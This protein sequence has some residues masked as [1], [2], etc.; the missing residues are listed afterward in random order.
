MSSEAVFE[1]YRARIYRHIRSLVRNRADAEDLTQ[2]TFLRA[3]QRLES[4]KEPAALGVWLYRI[5]THVCYDHLRRVS[6]QPAQADDAAGQLEELAVEGPGLDQLVE[7]AE[8]IACGEVFLDRLPD[9]YRT[10]ILLH[11]LLDLSSV[12]IARLLRC[13]PGSVKIRLHRAR[14][15]FRAALEAGC[16]FYRNERGALVGEPKPRAP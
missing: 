9:G 2:E 11:D 13:T 15:R 14:A 16:E 6:R 1:Q 3:H 8:M 7:K 12:E 4:L 10:V 5:A